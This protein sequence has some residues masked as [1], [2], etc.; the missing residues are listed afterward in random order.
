MIIRVGETWNDKWP[1]PRN[2][3]RISLQVEMFAR[4]N[5]QTRLSMQLTLFNFKFPTILFL[6]QLLFSFFIST[7]SHLM[8]V[9]S[10]TRITR[11]R[12]R[13]SL[14][15]IVIGITYSTVLSHQRRVQIFVSLFRFYF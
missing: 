10:T 5:L 9:D 7:Y 8:H 12:K 14:N 6:S 1:V 2:T 11:R 13:M 4:F 15:R 3:S